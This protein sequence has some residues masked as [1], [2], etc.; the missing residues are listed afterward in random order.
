MIH[1]QSAES[2][3]LD[4]DFP[5][6]IECQLLGG[7]DSLPQSTANVCTPGTNVVINGKLIT[8]HCTNSTSPSFNGEEWVTVEVVVWGDSIVHY[9]VNGD[10]VMT[11]T[12]LQIGGGM[13]P[14]GFPLKDGTPLKE[15]YIAIQAETAPTEFRKIELL[16][17]SRKQSH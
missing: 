5:V 15:G 11:Y 7:T 9:L 4:E 3:G 2:M 6:S 13:L 10:T 14:E 17:L 12:H 1:S 16:D 8:Q